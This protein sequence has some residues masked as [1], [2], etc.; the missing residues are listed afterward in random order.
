MR[1]EPLVVF[2]DLD[3]TML[4][5]TTYRFDAARAAI[6]RLR[7]EGV[8]LVLCTSKTR[9][10][11]EP[12]RV[13]LDNRDPFI[14]ENGGGVYIPD[15]YFPF[16]I[17]GAE[18]HGAHWLIRIGDPY[19]DLVHAL[20]RASRESGVGVRGFAGMT[21]EEVAGATGLA[22]EDARLAREREFDE[23]FTL[24]EPGR[25]DALLA[26]IERAGKRCTRGG[27]FYHIMGANDKAVAVRRV[28]GLYRRHGGAVQTIGLGDAPND[29]AFL[30]VVDV[31]IL[32]ASSQ[33]D[34]LC[35]LVPRGQP[36]T[37]AGPAGWN[38][39]VL[40]VLDERRRDRAR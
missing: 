25:P 11:V 9:A 19:A 27:R 3:G 13:A 22:V 37:L 32:I 40:A 38:E 23:P 16:E 8:P 24:V 28:I 33:T 7:A 14:V 5:H 20:E 15:R 26:A 36:T 18:R 31:P 35:R 1:R 21:D 6:D 29:A 12:V 2:S 30:N 17:E 10:E 39:A 34:E 4:D